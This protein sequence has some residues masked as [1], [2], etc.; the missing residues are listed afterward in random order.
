MITGSAG[1]DNPDSHLIWSIKVFDP[2]QKEKQSIY[3]YEAERDTIE[4]VRITEGTKNVKDIIHEKAPIES[5]SDSD[6]LTSVNT[7]L[8]QMK[9][10]FSY[11]QA[12][13]DH[14]IQK[15]NKLYS[16]LPKWSQI[17]PAL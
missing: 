5:L 10:K 17:I 6:L 2:L 11:L 4:Y 7:Y 13:I 16:E 8:R 15:A 9:S 14:H 3:D 12:S 1:Q